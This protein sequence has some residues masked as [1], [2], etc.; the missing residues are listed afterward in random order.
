MDFKLLVTE[1]SQGYGGFTSSDKMN[2]AQERWLL[3]IIRATQAIFCFCCS[4][5]RNS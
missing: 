1:T 3:R 4:A 2:W 5:Q